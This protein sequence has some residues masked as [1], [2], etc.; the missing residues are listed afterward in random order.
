MFFL[1]STD[2]HYFR[3]VSEFARTFMGDQIRYAR[4]AFQAENTPY[5]ES[6]LAEL[7]TLEDKIP[8]LK[9]AFED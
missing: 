2:P 4:N 9:Y 6:V 7:K 1:F 5:R 8:D 3:Q